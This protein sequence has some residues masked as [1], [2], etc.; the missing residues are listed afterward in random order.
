MGKAVP[1][2]LLGFDSSLDLAIDM[3]DVVEVVE[4]QSG[5]KILHGIPDESTKDLAGVIRS[6]MTNFSGFN[7]TTGRVLSRVRGE[8]LEKVTKSHPGALPVS[9][10]TK[11]K[12][13]ELIRQNI[14]G[15]DEEG[16]SF[17]EFR[18]RFLAEAGHPLDIELW[19][20]SGMIDFITLG[21]PDI[22]ELDLDL[23][24]VWKVVPVGNLGTQPEH[25]REGELVIKLRK[26]LVNILENNPYGLSVKKLLEYKKNLLDP[27]NCDKLLEVALMS[28]DICFVDKFQ[29][30]LTIL[31]AGFSYGKSKPNFPLHRLGDLK[32][33]IWDLIWPLKEKVALATLERALQGLNARLPNPAEFNCE[34]FLEVLL[35]MPDVIK[36]S[37]NK[38]G[39]FM[40]QPRREGD[41][42]QEDEDEVVTTLDIAQFP[43]DLLL[44][45]RRVLAEYPGGVRGRELDL[46][47][48]RITGQE[49]RCA[50]YTN[51]NTLLRD[52]SGRQGFTYEG[53]RFSSSCDVLMLP[54]LRLP[55][56]PSGWVEITKE[57]GSSSVLVVS[58]KISQEIWNLE[59]D[60]EE[61]YLDPSNTRRLRLPARDCVVGQTVAA[62]YQDSA[63]YRARILH[64]MKDRGGRDLAK[65][66]YVDHG[67][68][69]LLPRSALFRLDRVFSRVPQQVVSVN[70]TEQ[71]HAEGLCW[72][73]NT[74]EAARIVM[75]EW[76]EVEEITR[77]KPAGKKGETELMNTKTLLTKL[78]LDM[79]IKNTRS[80]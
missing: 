56:L 26:E 68:T 6:Q 51:T 34:T 66:L 29:S 9:D 67:W 5:D 73:D 24:G 50:G 40:I 20:Y 75:A 60:M 37:R 70:L 7:F 39:T 38:E 64:T 46:H 79:I 28:P 36:V 78:I 41:T 62:L 42:E 17:H 55:D 2:R 54:V 27:A 12:L 11:K 74:K 72:L 45:L 43:D 14:F 53:D 22:L 77:G 35:L 71:D 31:P 21:V 44:N 30:E 58:Q 63:I 10:Y 25:D 4:L 3:P 18:E 32:T 59:R 1:Y 33:Q 16:I 65:V 69:A 15:G 61:F 47:Y 19:G 80:Q 8:D 13:K 23:K 76:V 48:K 49:L 57:E 52:L